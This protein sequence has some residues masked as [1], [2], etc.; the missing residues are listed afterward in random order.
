MSETTWE[1]TYRRL[2]PTYDRLCEEVVYT[3]RTRIQAEGIKLH[4]LSSRVK[5]LESLEEKA[6]RKGYT[7]PLEDAP[8]VVGVRAVV[9]F[10]SDMAKIAEIVK[11]EFDVLGTSDT[12]AGSD[13]PTTFGYMSQHFEACMPAHHR[14]PRYEGLSGIRL[15]I[16]VRT[17][18]MDAWANVSHYLAYKN[19]TS[20]PGELRRDFNALS[21]LFYVADTHFEMFFDETRTVRENADQRLVEAEGDIPLN[22]D[23][24]VAFLQQRYP[25]RK[26]DERRGVGE[27]ASELLSYGF[28]TISQL[29]D[30]LAASEDAFLALEK[31]FPP[32]KMAGERFI[33]VGVVRVSMGLLD[34]SL[35]QSLTEEFREKQV[36]LRVQ[37]ELLRRPMSD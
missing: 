17:L 32:G 33:D 10:R 29:E 3:L 27:L 7:A 36:K 1:E 31:E 21:G 12:V 20:I 14:G 37:N 35:A 8:D 15:E 5:D 13:D 16:Q 2:G 6:Q 23:T 28:T 30:A 4:S 25:D 34:D 19:E 18:L 9:L 11:S 26:H 24:L 22:L